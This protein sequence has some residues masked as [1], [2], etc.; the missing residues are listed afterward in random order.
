MAAY[1][2]SVIEEFTIIVVNQHLFGTGGDVVG[3]DAVDREIKRRRYMSRIPQQCSG[4]DRC[5]IGGEQQIASINVL[6]FLPRLIR[7]IPKLVILSRRRRAVVVV[8]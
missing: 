3:V 8:I 7:N 5:T 4:L 6:S 1:L 2:L